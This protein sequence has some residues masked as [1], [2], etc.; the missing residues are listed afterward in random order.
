MF[1]PILTPLPIPNSNN[2]LLAAGDQDRELHLS[3]LAP[4][5]LPAREYDDDDPPPPPSTR[6][7]WSEEPTLPRTINNSV[8]LISLSLT[9]S[10]E[11]RVEPRVAVSAGGGQ[12]LDKVGCLT[13]DVPVN[14]SS[15]SPDG[16][17]LLSV[18]DSPQVTSP[19]APNSSLNL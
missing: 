7:I 5:N 13:L 2:I 17:T 6:P 3:L 18:G 9:Q 14:H 1:P 12:K 10:N 16:R 11:S 8:M 15:V 19:A 4:R